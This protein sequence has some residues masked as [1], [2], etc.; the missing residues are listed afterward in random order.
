MCGLGDKCWGVA[1]AL[2]V[3]GGRGRAVR[4]NIFTEISSVSVENLYSM[5]A[6]P[7]YRNICLPISTVRL[8]Q[9]HFR[10]IHRLSYISIKSLKGE[11]DIFFIYFI[12]FYMLRS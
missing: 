7:R 1:G 4:G 3:A 10:Q 9:E 2:R 8:S 12:Y 6:D 11:S 5:Y